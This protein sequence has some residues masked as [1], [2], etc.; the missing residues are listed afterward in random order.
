MDILVVSM[1]NVV[2]F[3]VGGML[4]FY[5]RCGSKS[6]EVLLVFNYGD[7]AWV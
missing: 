7:V 5:G 3:W 1:V 2:D 4:V 6:A